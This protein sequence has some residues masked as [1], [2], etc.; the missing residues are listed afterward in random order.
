[1]FLAI[2]TSK[3]ES[4]GRKIVAVDPRNTSR[5][6]PQCGHTAKE[7]RPTQKKFHC[8]SC[9]HAAHADTVGAINVLNRVGLVRCNANTA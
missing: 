1:M 6:C 7:N 5:E 4:A 9:G 3:A 2:L 8:V